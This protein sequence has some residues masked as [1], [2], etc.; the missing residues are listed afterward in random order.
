MSCRFSRPY[1]ACP[2]QIL[3]ISGR[4]QSY[5]YPAF[6]APLVFAPSITVTLFHEEGQ[7]GNLATPTKG[8][9]AGNTVP[10]WQKAPKPQAAMSG[11][12]VPAAWSERGYIPP[13]Q[14]GIKDD[15]DEKGEAAYMRCF[16]ESS[17]IGR[18]PNAAY[19]V[20]SPT[21]RHYVERRDK[22]LFPVKEVSGKLIPNP[23]TPSW[24]NKSEE[25][26]NHHPSGP[27]GIMLSNN[28]QGLPPSKTINIPLHQNIQPP[29]EHAP[30]HA[31]SSVYQTYIPWSMEP[32]TEARGPP[33][34]IR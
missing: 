4:P 17:K 12:Q 16:H 14:L 31:P 19:F 3:F 23:D 22:E 30:Q 1:P 21:A 10:F 29:P 34:M 20:N 7:A 32:Q 27:G 8:H 28:L 2:A 25:P 9:Q 24:L 15:E 18:V 13:E 26:K 33:R 5:I 6:S 11:Q